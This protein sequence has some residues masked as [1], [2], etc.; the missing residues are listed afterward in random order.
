[1][2]KLKSVCAKNVQISKPMW[3]VCGPWSLVSF[4]TPET[5]SNKAARQQSSM[6]AQLRAFLSTPSP[7]HNTSAQTH[8]SS[9]SLNAWACGKRIQPENSILLSYSQVIWEFQEF[10]VYQFCS[11]DQDQKSR[12]VSLCWRSFRWACHL[13]SLLGLWQ[14]KEKNITAHGER[15]GESIADNISQNFQQRVSHFV[16]VDEGEMNK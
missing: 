5:R 7:S 11:N 9:Y 13:E 16:V 4:Y 2:A 12:P 6:R 3:Q 1:M 8:C 15:V 14:G 10:V